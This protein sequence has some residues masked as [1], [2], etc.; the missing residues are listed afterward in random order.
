MSSLSGPASR[1]QE[2][3]VTESLLREAS[4]ESGDRRSELVR[5]AI[6][7]GAAMAR[8]LALRYDGRGVD[9]EELFQVAYVG[10]VKAAHGYRP[11]AETDFRSYAFPT[12][13]GEL[14]RHFRDNAWAV[15]PPR[16]IQE[17]QAAI[18]AAESELATQLHRW[19]T[20]QELA[21]WIGVPVGEISAAQQAR[22]CFHPDSLD[23][24]IR[25]GSTAP[26]GSLMADQEDT[27]ELVNQIETLRPAVEHLC[28]RDKLILRRRVIDHRSQAAIASEIG[29]S[30]MQVSRLLKRIMRI[31]QNALMT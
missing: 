31:L 6:V 7:N 5:D 4:E 13:R 27:Y 14:K 29:V 9:R 23:A 3:S 21:N 18:N 17:L 16:R 30:Q 11:G 19:P 26:L 28:E 1:E 22:G 10:L 20:E 2:R 25:T 24:P 12:I 8:S 15:R